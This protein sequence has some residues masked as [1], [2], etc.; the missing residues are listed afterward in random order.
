[1]TLGKLTVLIGIENPCFVEVK[2]KYTYF[3]ATK[4]SFADVDK[5]QLYLENEQT[6]EVKKA[7]GNKYPSLFKEAGSHYIG[8]GGSQGFAGN[9]KGIRIGVIHFI[10]MQQYDK[11]DFQDQY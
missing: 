3:P 2:Q 11:N 7:K 9:V 4:K 8:V 5:H 6:R 1:M 10:E